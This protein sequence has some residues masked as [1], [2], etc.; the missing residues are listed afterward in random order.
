LHSEKKKD[1]LFPALY[2]KD[3]FRSVIILTVKDPNPKT[4]PQENLNIEDFP[5]VCECGERY[6]TVEA[7]EDCSECL[8]GLRA[9][10]ERSLYCCPSVKPWQP[11]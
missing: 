9:E 4:M 5:H 7:A 6:R 8:E 1:Y 10:M 11:T 3:R 2:L